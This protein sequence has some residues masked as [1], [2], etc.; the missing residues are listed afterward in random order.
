MRID[1][2]T[3]YADF[4]AVIGGLGGA[5]TRVFYGKIG[6]DVLN[7]LALFPSKNIYVLMS[8]GPGIVNE[9]TFL[10]DFPAAINATTSAAY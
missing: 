3:N 8:I 10:T 7:S 1:I 4:Q 6:N 2:G 5:P 9:T